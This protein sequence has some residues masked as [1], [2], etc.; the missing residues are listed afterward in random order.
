MKDTM[1]KSKSVTVKKKDMG[2]QMGV[3]KGKSKET[4]SMKKTMKQKSSCMCG[5]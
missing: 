4:S 5:R 1:K 3:V 2:D